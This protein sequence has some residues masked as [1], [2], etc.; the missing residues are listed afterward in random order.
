M[1]R[2]EITAILLIAGLYALRMLGLFMVLPVLPLYIDTLADGNALW[3]GWAIG[4]YGLT[5][6]I[7]QIPLGHLSDKIGRKQVILG[8]LT[9]MAIGSLVAACSPSMVGILIG[10][11]LQ[12][13]GAIGATLMALAADVSAPQHRATAMAVIGIT[14]GGT[15]VLAMMLGPLI[16]SHF[17][18]SGIFGSI[19]SLS[20]LAIIWTYYKIPALQPSLSNQRSLVT[21]IA[22]SL[23]NPQLLRLNIS[24]LCLHAFFTASFLFIPKL[25]VQYSP[26]APQNQWC[27]YGAVLLVA[28][29]LM[30]IGLKGIEHQS[31][32]K[33]IFS[34]TI[35]MLGLS[36]LLLTGNGLSWWKVG[37]ALVLFF[38]AFT[39]LEAVLPAMVSRTAPSNSYGSALGIYSTFQFFG[40]FLGGSIGGAL[41]ASL[42]VFGITLWCMLLILIW[43]SL[44]VNL[45]LPKTVQIA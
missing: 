42:G 11:S 25:I 40:I 24:I 15:F 2:N 31:A 36:Q 7:F 12:G 6:A 33:W 9:M 39:L 43:L 41:Y 37:G 38:T 18:L 3:I 5:Q 13:A 44:V 16:N 45:Q 35:V 19:F 21:Q 14:I 10:R 23:K 30:R 4:S 8:G 27:L 22:T 34:S 1:T 29:L 28:L 26:V 20:L 17:G 32:G